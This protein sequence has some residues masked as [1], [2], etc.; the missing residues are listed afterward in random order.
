M[1]RGENTGKLKQALSTMQLSLADVL[2]GELTK[3][4]EY[5]YVDNRTMSFIGKMCCDLSCPCLG[6]CVIQ[7]DGVKCGMMVH[8]YDI[9]IHQYFDNDM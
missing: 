5:R 7:A 1:K 6:R 2:I 8:R 9:C 3:I 4:D